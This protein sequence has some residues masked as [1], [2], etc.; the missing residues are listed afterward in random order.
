[1]GWVNKYMRDNLLRGGEGYKDLHP[2]EIEPL[3]RS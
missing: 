1:M 3:R 2:I